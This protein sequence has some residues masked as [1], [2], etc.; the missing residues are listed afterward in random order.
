MALHPPPDRTARLL[1]PLPASPMV[2]YRPRS[3]RADAQRHG[4]ENLLARQADAGITHGH[5]IHTLRHGCATPL[6]EA[7]VDVR[8]IQMV[9]GHQALET[10]TR[11]LRIPRQP[12]ATLRSPCALLPGGGPPPPPPES[13]HAAA[14]PPTAQRRQPHAS[15][16][17][18]RGQSPL[19]SA[20][21][22][23]PPAVPIPYRPRR[24]RC[25][26]RSRPA[27]RRRAVGTPHHGPPGG[28][29]GM[30]RMP[31]AIVTARS[32]R[33]FPRSAGGRTGKPRA[34]LCPLAI[35]C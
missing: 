6:L 7:G 5:G 25:G 2:V 13:S 8:T 30:P 11:S 3:P 10:T 20:S 16:A 26:T 4:P 28:S 35:W 17:L 23:H 34:C 27:G 19:S 22:G 29:S 24:S 18:H 9:L 15:R 21:L 31:V 14:L 1:A 32:A 12:L 33:P